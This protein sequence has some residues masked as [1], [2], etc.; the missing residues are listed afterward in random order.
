MTTRTPRLAVENELVRAH[1]A[2]LVDDRVTASAA[3]ARLLEIALREQFL[4]PVV[5]SLPWLTALLAYAPPDLAAQLLRLQGMQVVRQ[6]APDGPPRA[7]VSTL[8][9]RELAVLDYLP[10]R[11]SNSE[12]SS[13]RTNCI[14]L[15]KFLAARIFC[16]IAAGKRA[17]VS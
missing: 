10:S 2:H 13:W 9:D 8:S 12:N 5:V 15:W 1:A 14:P 16:A 6:W 4:R 7:T 11:M 17:S 3:A